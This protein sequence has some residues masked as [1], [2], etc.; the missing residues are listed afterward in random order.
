MANIKDV[1]KLSGVGTSTVSRYFNKSGYVSEES[2]ERIQQACKELHYTPNALARAVKTKHA[3][4]ICLVVPNIS[5]FFFAELSSAIERACVKR[6]YKVLLVNAGD[7]ETLKEINLTRLHQGFID[8][9]IITAAYKDSEEIDFDVPVVFMESVNGKKHKYSA[10]YTDQYDGAMQACE[11]LYEQ[12]C[13]KIIYLKSETHYKASVER[14]RGYRD[15]LN[16]HGLPLHIFS[17]ED[18]DNK[19]FQIF[20]NHEYDGVFAWNDHLAAKFIERCHQAY[21]NLPEDVQL[22]GYDNVSLARYLY[23]QLTTIAQPIEALGTYAADSLI[24]KIEGIQ[25][26]EIRIVLENELII[27]KTT[28]NPE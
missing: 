23:P 28:K 26:E 13:R 21:V 3:Y 14:E 9:A 1:A 5:R 2:R 4:T 6:G 10:V 11:Y 25:K 27:R 16:Q 7:E 17:L 18:L 22:I 12:G 20:K 19:G 15:C 8:G 24:N